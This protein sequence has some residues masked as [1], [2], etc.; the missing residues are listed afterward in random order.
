MLLT[1]VAFTSWAYR[2]KQR[3]Q[4]KTDELERANRLLADTNTLLK[5][6]IAWRKKN[7]H[8]RQKVVDELEASNAEMERFTYTVSHDLKSPLITIR[9]FLGLLEKDTADGNLDRMKAD[10]QRIRGAVEQMGRLLDEL[11]ELSRVGRLTHPQQEIY[12]DE[13]A[14]VAV[15][16]VAGRIEN[17]GAE[18]EIEPDIPPT[19]GDRPRL[20]EV[21]QNLIDNAV[22]FM[23]EQKEPR[24]VVGSRRDGEAIVYYVRDNGAG[25]D[26]RYQKR[27]FDLFERFD[28]ETEGTGIGLALV[29]RIV[30][31]HGGR[32]WIESEGPGK[33]STFCFTVPRTDRGGADHGQDES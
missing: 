13:L 4:Q 15:E 8:E 29:K 19:F 16:M 10:M 12:I 26:P 11:L 20:L 28:Q 3:F 21:L 2:L 22:K 25:I 33:G 18:I 7:E 9:G 24:V 23:G 32:I 17:R 1:V 31:V 30:E 5:Q 6:H 27:V 14:R